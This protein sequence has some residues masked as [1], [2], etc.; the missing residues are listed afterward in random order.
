MPNSLL[1]WLMYAYFFIG[2]AAGWFLIGILANEVWARF[3]R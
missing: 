2:S 1:E 3:K